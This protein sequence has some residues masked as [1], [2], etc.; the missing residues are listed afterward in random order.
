MGFYIY[1]ILTFFLSFFCVHVQADT[2]L[3]PDAT[4][5]IDRYNE[6]CQLDGY[7][8][9]QKFFLEKELQN[10]TPQFDTFIDS[11]DL[12]NKDF[13][14]SVQKNIQNIL[15]SEMIS[16]S[17]LDMLAR[18]LEQVNSQNLTNPI[19]LSDEIKFIQQEITSNNKSMAK[20]AEFVVYFKTVISKKTFNKIKPSFLNLPYTVITFNHLPTHTF[21]KNKIIDEDLFLVK[22]TCEK[23]N[24]E[25]EINSLSWKILSE[26]S[27]GWSQTLT[28]SSSK[29]YST[30]KENKSWIF[31]G[32]LAI[33]TFILANQYE[34]S[35]QF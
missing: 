2:L 20:D 1:L 28:Q 13:L 32:A 33:G 27:C 29:I 30:I 18:L 5:T 7:V 23:A 31:V 14:D 17:Q 24:V 11:M 26:S 8:C 35:F 21:T 15:Q 6:K 12:T 10:S 16:L 34:V 4:I 19:K 25:S 3:I 9:T 22:G